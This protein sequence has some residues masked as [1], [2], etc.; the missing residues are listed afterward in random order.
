MLLVVEM[1]VVVAL[2]TCGNRSK[3]LPHTIIFKA[4]TQ[5]QL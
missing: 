1:V 4:P 5:L 3:Q 2:A